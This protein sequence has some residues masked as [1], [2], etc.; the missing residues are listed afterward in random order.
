MMNLNRIFHLGLMMLLLLLW[1]CSGGVGGTGDGP[2]SAGNA[3]GS[4]DEVALTGDD[5]GLVL[6]PRDIVLDSAAN[7]ALIVDPVLKAVVAIDLSS[8]VSSLLSGNTR[9]DTLN[10]FVDPRGIIL[11]EAR[12]RALV[13]D[14]GQK[15][16]IAVD[17]VTGAR[18]IFSDHT[19]PDG[20]LPLDDPSGIVLDNA[21]NRALVTDAGLQAVVG[22]DLSTGARSLLSD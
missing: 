12:N 1:G 14:A 3:D 21:N 15:A 9:P 11:D 7:R 16:V 10:A 17:L 6:M 4:F 18:N 20:K 2:E 5:A 13:V 19:T 8:G 22:V